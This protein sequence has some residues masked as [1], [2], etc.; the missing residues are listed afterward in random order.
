MKAVVVAVA[1]VIVSAFLGVP[2]VAYADPCINGTVRGGGPGGDSFLCQG[3][4]WLHVIPTLGLPNQPL[5]PTCA[6]LPDK[7]MCP[8]DGPPPGLEWTTPGRWF[9]GH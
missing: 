2:V 3:G 4:G 1:S 9:P 6:R 5:P 7:Y 8:I